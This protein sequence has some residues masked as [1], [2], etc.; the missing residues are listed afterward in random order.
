M[1]DIRQALV[2]LAS[3]DASLRATLVPLTRQADK[4]ESMPKGW[5]EESRKKFWESLTGGAPKHKVTKCIKEMEGKKG[6]DNPGAFCAALADRVMGKDWRKKPKKA[7]QEQTVNAVDTG[8]ARF[9][10]HLELRIN[11]HY[12]HEKPAIAPPTFTLLH[13]KSFIRL[14]KADGGL[15]REAVAFISRDSGEVFP[16]LGWDQPSALPVANI[17]DSE[18]WRHFHM[19]STRPPQT[20]PLQTLPDYGQDHGQN[21]LAWR[22]SSKTVKAPDTR[23]ARLH[24]LRQ[25][26]RLAELRGI[27]QARLK[28]AADMSRFLAGIFEPVK[29]YVKWRPYLSILSAYILGEWTEDLFDSVRGRPDVEDGP[30]KV[31]WGWESYSYTPGGSLEGGG[32]DVEFPE[33]LH[34]TWRVEERI[35]GGALWKTLMRQPFPAIRPDQSE[36]Y[37]A[38]VSRIAGDPKRMKHLSKV[39]R[40]GILFYVRNNAEIVAE[41]GDEAISDTFHDSGIREY[42]AVT[43]HSGLVQPKVK[44]SIQGG[45][46][47]AELSGRVYLK[48]EDA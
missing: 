27:R 17:M 45:K 25:Q 3:E 41:W 36:G 11:E 43:S 30:M 32:E 48:A 46:M 24:E 19:S 47:T 31:G 39:L 14:I 35:A 6:I 18:S 20:R 7:V 44:V 2:R 4:W 26:K 22:G 29:P 40:D 5:T 37:W 16:A 9:K 21:A 28:V 12:R 1:Q 10:D 38:A 42:E 13:G 34:F 33:W 23:L 15:H 8:A